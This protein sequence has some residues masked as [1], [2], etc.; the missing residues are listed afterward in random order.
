[1]TTHV[2]S[3]IF[4]PLHFRV[5]SSERG[6]CRKSRH[7]VCHLTTSLGFIVLVSQE[8]AKSRYTSV[9][10]QLGGQVRTRIDQCVISRLQAQCQTGPW[11]VLE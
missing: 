10:T 3:R 4:R 5:P 1:M 2:G 8:G 9:L 6:K 7:L 11:H